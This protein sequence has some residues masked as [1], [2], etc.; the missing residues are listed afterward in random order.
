MI[1][2]PSRIYSY[3]I[4]RVYNKSNENYLRFMT[5]KEFTKYMANYKFI[6]LFIYLFIYHKNYLF[7]YDIETGLTSAPKILDY[8]SGNGVSSETIIGQLIKL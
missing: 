1:N 6:Y 2:M 3:Y 4:F 5:F 7:F 8:S